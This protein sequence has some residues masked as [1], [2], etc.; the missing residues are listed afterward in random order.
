MAGELYAISSSLVE[1]I[2]TTPSVRAQV[3]GKEDKVTARW[4]RQ[5]PQA[6]EVRWRSERCWIYDHPRAGTVYSHGFLFPSE[7]EKVRREISHDLTPAGLHLLP[8]AAGSSASVG[9]GGAAAADPSLT[10]STVSRFGAHYTPPS[11]NLTTEQEVEALVEGSALSR[12]RDETVGGANG[13]ATHREVESAWRRRESRW[14]RTIGA[15]GA[16][17]GEMATGAVGGTILVHFIKRNE[18]FLETAI[19]FLEDEPAP[20]PLEDGLPYSDDGT[21]S[22]GKVGGGGSGGNRVETDLSGKTPLDLSNLDPEAI[23]PS[24]PEPEPIPAKPS[25]PWRIETD[26]GHK[27]PIDLT[28]LEGAV[29]SGIVDIP[30][31][32][33]LEVDVADDGAVVEEGGPEEGGDLDAAGLDEVAETS[34]DDGVGEPQEGDL[35]P[36][37]VEPP[38]TATIIEDPNPEE[39]KPHGDT[40]DVV[41]PIIVSNTG[42]IAFELDEESRSLEADLSSL[43]TP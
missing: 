28:H 29:E 17:G 13:E 16:D 11:L 25:S 1:Y 21:P 12:L 19:A 7:V 22:S 35:Q 33:E 18:W 26:F 37:E 2:A 27:T 38:S 14:M 32:D 8:H 5:H 34:N 4:I 15:F 24:D 42:A 31:E 3:Q 9:V 36:L 41:S 40:I 39:V 6:S 10:H 20:P 30:P 43:E 23:P